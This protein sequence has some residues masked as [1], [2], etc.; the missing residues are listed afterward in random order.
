MH[1]QCVLE[2]AVVKRCSFT[3]MIVFVPDYLF[4]FLKSTMHSLVLPFVFVFDTFHLL[5]HFNPQILYR[6]EE[7]EEEEFWWKKIL[8]AKILLSYYL[9]A[10]NLKY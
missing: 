3:A 2:V 8:F 6:D 10:L 7:K 9:E 1:Y 4:H 5:G